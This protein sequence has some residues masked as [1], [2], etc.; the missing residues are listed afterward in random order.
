M[1]QVKTGEVMLLAIDASCP[2]CGFPEVSGHA[3]FM[4]DGPKVEHYSCRKCGWRG[5]ERPND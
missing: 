4:S 3:R 2:D 1:S 5:K